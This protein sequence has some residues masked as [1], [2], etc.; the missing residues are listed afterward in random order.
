MA[1]DIS[2]EHLNRQLE[3][4]DI[5]NRDLATLAGVSESTIYRWLQGKAPVPASVVRM[6]ALMLHV[7]QG[8]ELIGISWAI[9]T[10]LEEAE[11]AS[12]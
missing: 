10:D 6:N 5:T 7:R 3:Q 8:Q 12:A 11:H 1:L 2:A 4:L 9:P